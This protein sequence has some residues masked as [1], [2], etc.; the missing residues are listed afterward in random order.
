MHTFIV[1]CPSEGEAFCDGLKLEAFSHQQAAELWAEEMCPAITI[2]G[3][4]VFVTR[5]LPRTHREANEI[6]FTISV[7]RKFGF[8]STYIAR[9]V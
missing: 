3:I 9:R 8:S 6:P 7:Y 5:D 4:N 2:F 1:W